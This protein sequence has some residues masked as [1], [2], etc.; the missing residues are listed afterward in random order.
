MNF[1]RLY[2]GVRIDTKGFDEF[3]EVMRI[4]IGRIVFRFVENRMV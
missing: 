2:V 1:R 4:H 3:L